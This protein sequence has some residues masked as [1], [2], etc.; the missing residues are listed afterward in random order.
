MNMD[1]DE[2]LKLIKR[3]T[4]EIITDSELNSLLTEKKD[5]SAYCGRAPTGAMHLGHLVA[6]G[7]L[8]DFQKAGIHAKILLADIH[9]ALDDLK[10]KWEDLDKRVDYTKKCFELSFDWKE[11]PEF[12]RGSDFE[13]DKDYIN[14][15]LKISTVTTID[16]AL[17]AASE[18]TRMKNPKVSELI[19]PIMQS[20]DEQYL[21]VDIQLGSMDQRHIFVFAREHLPI[22]GYRKRVEIMVP[23]ITS[24]LG[25]GSKMSSSLPETHIKVYDSEDII[26]RKIARAYCPLGVTK[27]NFVVDVAK[28]LILPSDEKFKIERAEKFGG[29]LEITSSEELER[30]YTE[31]KIHPEDLKSTVASYLIKKLERV[32]KYFED[33]QDILKELGEEFLSK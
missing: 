25:P 8:L 14:D 21:D 30:L 32:R 7:K 5:I 22:L 4:S 26:R 31:K 17:R 3:N 16:R 9:A 24:L 12:V 1:L 19:Y 13:L 29:D 27:D 18:V 20:L 28:Y 2:R 15:M 6:F 23:F 33:R 10:S 11:K